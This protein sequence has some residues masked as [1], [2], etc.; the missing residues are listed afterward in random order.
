VTVQTWIFVYN[1]LPSWRRTSKRA[2]CSHIPARRLFKIA[3]QDSH[4]II[5]PEFPLEW[6]KTFS[7]NSKDY[8][9]GDP[10][11]NLSRVSTDHSWWDNQFGSYSLKD[12]MIDTI[13]S[14]YHKD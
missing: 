11:Y 2:T 3:Q 10:T 9:C 1:L 4:G 14:I 7:R 8:R 5:R 6:R 13:D 12:N